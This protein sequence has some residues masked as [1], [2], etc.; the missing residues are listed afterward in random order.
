MQVEA[1]VRTE[2]IVSEQPH[3][4]C[5]SDGNV[6]APDCQ[7]VLGP[8][9]DIAFAATDGIGRNGHPFKDAVWVALEHTAVHESAGVALVSV[10]DQVLQVSWRLPAELPLHAGGET[11]ATAPAQA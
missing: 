7:R 5:L 6:Q 10:A 2:D 9:V 1:E 4:L 11:P 3:L 8:A